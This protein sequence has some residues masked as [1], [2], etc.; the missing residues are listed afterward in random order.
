MKKCVLSLLLCGGLTLACVSQ[1]ADD[2]P[3]EIEEAPADYQAMENPILPEE[4]TGEDLT[5]IGQLYA[6]KCGEKCHG[7]NGDSKGK[8][9]AKMPLKP[10]AFNK[11][12][13]LAGKKD[14]QLFWIIEKGSK[15]SEM[16]PFGENTEHN[17]SEDDIWELIHYIRIKF[18]PP[19]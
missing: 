2:R 9:T 15:D 11:P 10:V 12:G 3:Y 7:V 14:G 18:T 8:D 1:A 4:L 16:K 6:T 17:L 5:R 19:Q 13:Y